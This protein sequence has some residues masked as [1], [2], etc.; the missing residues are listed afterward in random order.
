MKGFPNVKQL[1]KIRRSLP[2]GVT[3]SLDCDVLIVCSPIKPS[4]GEGQLPAVPL[5]W[6]VRS[7]T[8]PDLVYVPYSKRNRWVVRISVNDRLNKGFATVEEAIV[9]IR[10]T[11]P[12]AGGE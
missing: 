2:N 8:F 3:A 11:Y 9:Y 5:V 10:M 4:N 1:E 12:K 7:A 6:K